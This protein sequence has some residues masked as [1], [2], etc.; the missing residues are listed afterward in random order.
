M[1]RYMPSRNVSARGPDAILG[2]G[3]GVIRLTTI[4]I[5]IVIVYSGRQPNSMESVALSSETHIV[6]LTRLH[7]W[8][9]NRLA[10]LSGSAGAWVAERADTSGPRRTT[11]YAVHFVQSFHRLREVF[12][13]RRAVDEIERFIGE[14][15]GRNIPVAE[16]DF[17]MRLLGVLRCSFSRSGNP[18]CCER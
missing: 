2:R 5:G 11:K 12:E 8:R 4:P 17:H 13:R 18:C 16:I 15:H 6:H 14:R 1:F 7:C 9:P 3:L 10:V